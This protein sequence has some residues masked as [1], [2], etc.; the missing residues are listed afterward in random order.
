LVSHYDIDV[1]G[2]FVFEGVDH[3]IKR[4]DAMLCKKPPVAR[5]LTRDEVGSLE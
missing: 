3:L 2:I 4:I 5:L 1:D